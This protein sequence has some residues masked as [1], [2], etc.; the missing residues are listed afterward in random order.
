MQPA[1][2]DTVSSVV[3]LPCAHSQLVWSDVLI[4][5]TWI[6]PVMFDDEDTPTEV[7]AVDPGPAMFKVTGL[8]E[9]FK[10]CA[11]AV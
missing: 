11:P 4:V 8:G 1:P 2:I 7:D 9:K 6:F 10:V 3:P 5:V